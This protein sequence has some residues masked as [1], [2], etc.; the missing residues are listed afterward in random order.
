MFYYLLFVN[1]QYPTNLQQFLQLFDIGTLS[2][3]PNPTEIFFPDIEEESVGSPHQFEEQE[4]DGLFLVNAGS[5]I[6]VWISAILLIGLIFICLRY[7]KAL[8]DV[9]KDKLKQFKKQIVWSGVLRVWITTYL[10]LCLAS[11]LQL[12]VVSFGSVSKALSSLLGIVLFLLSLGLPVYIFL[13]IYK[14]R[15]NL[16]KV[17]EK[18]GC[19]LDEFRQEKTIHKYFMGIVIS[20]RFIF[21]FV[22]V[23]VSDPI[24]QVF[25]TIVPNVAIIVLMLIY[26][27]Y[28]EK[29][30][31]YNILYEEIVY[32]LCYVLV[33]VLAFGNN[34]GG[35]SNDGSTE[36][37]IGWAIITMTLLVLGVSL[38]II[39]Y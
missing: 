4:V 21:M 2:F 12:R 29:R 20:R 26:K 19:L 39:I 17:K 32:F 1:T 5:M 13:K 14:N 35:L 30:D 11:F 25:L 7:I 28:K 33:L 18:Q 22:L 9:I 10:E 27:P 38:C 23:F 31:Q 36:E 24:A 6:F 8:P 3:L 16:E 34:S 15:N 37:S